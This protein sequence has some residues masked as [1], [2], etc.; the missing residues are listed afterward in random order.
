MVVSQ[1]PA[2]FQFLAD[3]AVGI[4]AGPHAPNFSFEFGVRDA[5]AFI[6]SHAENHITSPNQSPVGLGITLLPLSAG[7]V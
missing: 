2:D 6:L 5:S 7:K 3:F 4:A 1:L